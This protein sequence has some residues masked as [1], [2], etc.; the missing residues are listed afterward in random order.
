[1]SSCS[2]NRN[3]NEFIFLLTNSFKNNELEYINL[4]QEEFDKNKKN[5]KYENIEIKLKLK[6]LNNN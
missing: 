3:K 6:I 1:M 2:L 5:T 4:L